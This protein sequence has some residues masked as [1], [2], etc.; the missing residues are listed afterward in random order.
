MICK[1][2][3]KGHRYALLS[4]TG[5]VMMYF[6]IMLPSDRDQLVQAVIDSESVGSLPHEQLCEILEMALYQHNPV[7]DYDVT[8]RTDEDA[9]ISAAVLYNFTI[10]K[11]LKTTPKTATL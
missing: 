7:V 8:V 3:R 2:V 5:H 6:Y 1:I 10:Q 4:E 11:A 9:V